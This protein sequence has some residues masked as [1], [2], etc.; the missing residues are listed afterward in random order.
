VRAHRPDVVHTHLIHADLHGTLAARAVGHRQVVSTKHGF[1]P[2]RRHRAY[3]L[4]DRL[5]GSLQ[6]EIIVVSRGLEQR[7]RGNGDLGAGKA[8]IV[9]YGLDAAEFRR[10]AAPVSEVAGL[11]GPVVGTVSRLVPE[12]G[13]HVLLEAFA[14]CVRVLGSGSLAIVGDGPARGALEAE[15]RRRGVA[16]RVRFLGYLP[17]GRVSA[18]IRAFDAFV[19]PTFFPEGFGLVVLEAMA[20]AK[21]IVASRVISIPEIIADGRTGLVVPPGDVDALR[22]ALLRLRREP[23]LAAR[24]G[25]AAHREVVERFGVG[26]M[27]DDTARVYDEVL[28]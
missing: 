19:F 8:R 21:P 5:T 25:A 7:L 6:R 13:V 28:G 3:S 1:E 24:L 10:Q 15:A 9:Y 17:R 26:R 18:A 23:G 16:D 27:V 14:E 11:P 12:K 4:L 2:W 22:A 20:W